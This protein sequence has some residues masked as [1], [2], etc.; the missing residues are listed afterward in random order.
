MSLGHEN[1]TLETGVLGKRE[2]LL[3]LQGYYGCMYVSHQFQGC[4]APQGVTRS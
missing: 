3:F 4:W 1:V 2:Q